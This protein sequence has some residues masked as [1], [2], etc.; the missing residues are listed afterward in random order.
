[1]TEPK[2]PPFVLVSD[3]TIDETLEALHAGK[4]VLCLSRALVRDVDAF[5]ALPEELTVA[6]SWKMLRESDGLALVDVAGEQRLLGRSA[7]ILALYRLKYGEEL[8]PKVVW[9]DVRR[10]DADWRKRTRRGDHG[11]A[12]TS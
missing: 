11:P 8:P 12:W 6:V 2:P 4:V 10:T 9:M 3:V 5:D 1:M 7:P